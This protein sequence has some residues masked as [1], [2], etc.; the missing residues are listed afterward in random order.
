M[1]ETLLPAVVVVVRKDSNRAI[2]TDA[3][4]HELRVGDN[5]K[6]KEGEVSDDIIFPL[7]KSIF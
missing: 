7:L 3:D 1:N 6:E 4:G 2:A 5:V